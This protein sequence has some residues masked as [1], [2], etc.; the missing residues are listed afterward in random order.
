[1]PFELHPPLT[2]FPVALLTLVVIFEGIALARP[3]PGWRHSIEVLLV[4]AVLAVAA[5]FFSGYQASDRA[6]QTFTIAD[7]V[8]AWHHVM[9]RA[10]LFAI[11]P[12]AA[13]RFVAARARFNR[14]GFY[15]AYGFALA[16]CLGLVAYTGWLGGELVF[17]HGAGVRATLPAGAP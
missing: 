10:L 9:G 11:V 14:T 4:L 17:E 16:L 15:T 7:E 13:L 3:A 8:I 5:A 2:A 6:N 1:M 12:C